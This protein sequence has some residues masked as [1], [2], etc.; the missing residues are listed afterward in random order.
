MVRAAFLSRLPYPDLMRARLRFFAMH[1]AIVEPELRSFEFHPKWGPKQ[2]M[3]AFKDG[4]GNAF[5][6]WF[7]PKGAVVRGFHH[8]S[9]MSPFRHDPPV[10]WPGIFAGL[11]KELASA[12]TEPAFGEDEVTFA[13]WSRDLEGEWTSGPVRPPRGKDVDG[14]EELLACLLPN[15]EKW[16]KAYYDT[17][18]SQALGPL[19]RGEPITR[20][21]VIELNPQADLK[22]V[23]EE[24]ALLGWKTVNLEGTL[25]GADVK[26]RRPTTAKVVAK[27]KA[28][29]RASDEVR[30]RSFGQAEFYVRCEPTYVQMGFGK[31]VVAKANVD[32]YKELFDLVKA[33]LLLAKKTGK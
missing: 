27:A 11:P 6:A 21:M 2:Q 7:S 1:D 4:S 32:V 24:A 14:A 29:R 5:F 17:P 19:W 12:E 28:P 25:T 10:I 16:R 9:V 20:E 23:R 8:E 26:K 13:F 30:V 33:R 18:K 15:F 3:G 22:A 31:T